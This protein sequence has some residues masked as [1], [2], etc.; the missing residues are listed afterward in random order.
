MVEV[1]AAMAIVEVVTRVG[2][3]GC[4]AGGGGSTTA[5]GGVTGWLLLGCVTF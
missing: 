3:G 4:T 5:G 2:T 1:V